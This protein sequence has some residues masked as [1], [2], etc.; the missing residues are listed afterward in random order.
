VTAS[1]TL[2]GGEIFSFGIALGRPGLIDGGAAVLLL[3]PND[4]V[5]GDVR[6]DV[7]A[8]WQSVPIASGARLMNVRIAPIGGDGKYSGP[9]VDK[10]VNGATGRAGNWTGSTVPNQIALAATLHSAADLG[11]VKGR[12]YLPLPGAPVGADGRIG[13]GDR[14]SYE[15]AASNFVNNLGNQP[16]LDV[17]D[18]RPVIASQGRRNSDGS[19]KIGPANHVV[20]AV[21]VGR[22]LDTVRRRRNS[23]SEFRGTPTAV[24]TGS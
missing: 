20:T 16:G 3:D 4:T 19:V 10:P 13:E 22:T 5:W 12:F 14:D 21:S 11:R 24:S 1:G 7:E 8:Y 18:L 23:L 2:P 17:L 15:T 6:D 9:A